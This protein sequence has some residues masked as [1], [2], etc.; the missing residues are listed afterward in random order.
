M[1]CTVWRQCGEIG[2]VQTVCLEVVNLSVIVPLY[3]QTALLYFPCVYIYTMACVVTPMPV[4]PHLYG[5][6]TIATE[7]AYVLAK[8]EQ[9]YN[10]FHSLYDLFILKMAYYVIIVHR[11]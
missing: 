5:P 9:L 8:Y 2:Q 6:V 10:Y 4:I 1:C 11:L 7:Q 3:S